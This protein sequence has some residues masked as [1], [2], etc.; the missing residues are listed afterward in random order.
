[1]RNITTMQLVKDMGIGINL[2]NTF[3][4][5]CNYHN[6][7]DADRP[8]GPPNR[9]SCWIANNV[10]AFETAWGSP[11]ITRAMIQGYK[12]SGFNTVRVPVAWS[13]LMTRDLTG[14]VGSLSAAAGSGDP[15]TISSALMSRVQQVVDWVLQEDMYVILNVHWDGGWWDYFP[16][17]SA[18]CMQKFE[19]IWTQVGQHFQSYG[20]RLIFASLNEEGGWQRVWN[21]WSNAGDKQRSYNLLNAINQRFVTLIRAQSGNN[22]NRHLQVQGYYTDIDLTVDPMFRVP[23]D[24]RGTGNNARVAVSV[25]YYDPFSFTHLER[26]EE[27]A[28]MTL[29]WGTAA[30]RNHL[31]AQMDKLKTRFVD[32]G[33]PVIIGE[34]GLAVHNPPRAQNQIRDYTLAVTRA[35]YERNMLPV[36][37]DVQL[38]A[39]N[40]EILYYYN[41]HN[42]AFV[43][44]QMVTGFRNITAPYTSV[45]HNNVSKSSPAVSPKVSLKGKT[46][47]VSSPEN[48]G[49]MQVRVVD[50]KGK[51][52]ANFKSN[53]G[54]ANFSLSKMPAGRYFVEVKSGNFINTS[55]IVLK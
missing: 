10:N 32:N 13:N 41:R 53:G 52:R 38:N 45:N 48:A 19:R 22:P 20:D 26:N 43:D 1:M 6:Q 7:S 9:S 35:M 42:A 46:L 3:E 4:S 5:A 37:W 16:T 17:D 50:V 23:T 31:N 2:G 34:Y 14:S 30:E 49:I 47:N 21:R 15:F 44:Q 39:G 33:V 12:A 36:L 18:I 40:G 29:T 8:A 11:A 51:V 28:Q 54:G 55:S 24:Q 25:H 27:W